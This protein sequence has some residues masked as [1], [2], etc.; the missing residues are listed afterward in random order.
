MPTPDELNEILA[1]ASTDQEV[2]YFFE[3][4]ASPE[5]I[6]ALRQRG[7]FAAPPEP[8]V[9]GDGIRFPGWSRSRYLARVAGGDPDLVMTVLLDIQ[10]TSN[11]RIWADIMKALSEM[12][13]PYAVGFLPQIRRWIHSPYLLGAED[14]AAKIGSN[15]AAAGMVDEALAVLATF[16]ALVAPAGQA[17]GEAW[18][19]LKDWDYGRLVPP[20]ARIVAGVSPN[21]IWALADQLEAAFTANQ[22][23]AAGYSSLWRPAIEHHPQNWG[24]RPRLE[25]LVESIDETALSRIAEHTEELEPIVGGLLGRPPGILKRIGLHILVERGDLNPDLVGSVLTTKELFANTEFH[26]E[27]YRLANERF[28]EISDADRDLYLE[29][30]DEVGREKRRGEDDAKAAATARWWAL[31][32]LGPVAEYLDGPAEDRYNTLIADRG[33]PDHPDFLMW[34][35]TWSGPTSPLSK[36]ELEAKEVDD[37]AEFLATWTSPEGFGPHPSRDGLARELQ[38]AAAADPVRY[39]PFAERLMTLPPIY[40]GWFLL[41]LREALKGETT[42]D[43]RPAIALCHAVVE[44]SRTPEPDTD[45]PADE[46]W[47]SSRI[48]AARFLEEALARSRLADD[49]NGL[50]W[51]SIVELL[52][53][54]DPS[55]TTEGAYGDPLTHSL[56]T[57]RGQAVHAALAYA[58]WSWRRVEN[59]EAWRLNEAI[60]DVARALEEHLSPGGD[61]SD[62]IGAAYGWWLEALVGLD[63]AWVEEHAVE[64]LGDLS[65]PRELA[66]WGAY[67]MR[68]HPSPRNFGVLSRFYQRYAHVLAASDDAPTEKSAT[69]DPVERFIAHLV[70]L[71]LHGE[72][73][74]EGG[75]LGSV[76]SSRRGWLLRALVKGAGRVAHD[77]GELPDPLPEA[78]HALWGQIREAIEASGDPNLR[79]VLEEFSWWFASKLPWSWTLPEL[80]NLLDS[81]VRVSPEFLVLPRLAEVATDNE[82]AVLRALEKMV[83]RSDD[84]WAFRAHESDIRETLRIALASDDIVTRGRAKALIDRLGRLGMLELGSL[85]SRTGDPV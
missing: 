22:D 20:L 59:R 35:E 48:D 24:H 61:P 77:S 71:D 27:F 14:E 31:N 40:A 15:F 66:A 4:L 73:P 75:P 43:V 26:H 80:I 44:R 33:L 60:P 62:A 76:L 78:F 39:A 10:S 11:P 63:A 13:A 30:V 84:E 64:L 79:T 42:F 72:L 50:A 54:P 46:T 45:Q 5:W 47:Q 19:A 1:I 85:I 28:G 7:M 3:Q 82:D 37:L 17:T 65:T 68:S 29:L 81:G 52:R 18:V 6:P 8:I 69:A 12:P 67:L 83:P 23:D 56:N 16:A 34:H 74:A 70:V 58:W 2:D 57:T 51:A 38:G 25:A 32:R 9:E 21:A 49:D 53:D 55:P 41:G 36:A